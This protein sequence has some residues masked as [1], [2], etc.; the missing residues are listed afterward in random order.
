MELASWSSICEQ[1]D[2][3]LRRGVSE[4]PATGVFH[5]DTDI[6]NDRWKV[7]H[8]RVVEHVR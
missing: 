3:E 6:G 1:F 8:R 5:H 7:F 4:A 2:T